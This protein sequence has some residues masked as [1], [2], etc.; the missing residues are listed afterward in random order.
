MPQKILVATDGS[1]RAEKAVSYAI[2]LA[3]SS[4]A[5]LNVLSVVD[6]GSPRSALEIDPDNIEEIAEE[7][8]VSEIEDARKRIE[9][10]I[11]SHAS[12]M[13]SEA[14]VQ[15]S[16][17]VRIGTPADEIVK[18]AQEAGCDLIV[19]GTH[20]RGKLAT[21]VMGNVA[22]SVIHAGTTPV[23]VVP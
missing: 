13:A 16:G 6:S 15:T 7:V 22:T 12:K 17:K 9:T 5:E 1:P 2:D 8:D 19:M 20:G 11:V 14:G 3:K 21:A 23:L 4:G 18:Q 10:Q